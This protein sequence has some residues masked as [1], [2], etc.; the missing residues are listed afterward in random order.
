MIRRTKY[1]LLFFCVIHLSLSFSQNQSDSLETFLKHLTADDTLKVNTLNALCRELRN[2]GIYPQA[3]EYG[4]QAESISRKLD[5]KVGLGQALNNLGIIQDLQG[6]YPG[7]LDYYFKALKVCE[8]AGD[9]RGHAR[10]LNNIGII[11]NYQNNND[12]AREYYLKA[13]KIMEQSGDKRGMSMALN[14]VGIIYKKQQN[15]SKALYYYFKALK[16]REE[17]GDQQSVAAS[18][19]NIGN[20]YDAAGEYEK[21]KEYHLKSLKIR[22][23]IEDKNG[24]TMTYINLSRL[25]QVQKNYPEGIMYAEKSLK[26]AGEIGS[27]ALAEE[28]HQALYEIYLKMNNT[29]KALEHYKKYIAARDTIFNKENTEQTMRAEMNFEFERQKQQEKLLQEKRDALH[30]EEMKRQR[31]LIYSMSAGLLFLL[32]FALVIFSNYRQKKNANKMLEEKNSIIEEKNKNITDSINYARRIQ[33]AILPDTDEIYS[34]LQECFILY[35]PKDIVSGDFYYFAESGSKI[36]IAAA[37]CTGHGV[38]GAFMSM[39]GNDALN[40]IIIGKGITTP[41][42]ILSKLHDGVRFALKQDTSKTETSDGM[43]L[44]LCSIDRSTNLV[45]YAGAL[46]NL[47]IARKGSA[48]IEIIKANKQSIG[49]LKSD[50]KKTFS[51]QVIP[52]QKGDS[53][54]MLTDGYADQFGGKDGKKFM[55]RQLK[56]FLISIQSKNMKKQGEALNERIEEWKGNREQVD[57]ILVIGIRL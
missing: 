17:L 40:E 22:E 24:I 10:A 35:K 7:A 3:H 18:Y 39:I 1:I 5:Y 11:Y 38:P 13:L 55:M 56:D 57:D 8:D 32:A 43:D 52:L 4:I 6:D 27:L 37:D 16:L 44:A 33:N 9:K 25:S 53:I 49:G 21:A 12:K 48:E 15:Y 45:E 50:E 31:W 23:Q 28:A 20:M 36:I 2:T 34:K 14:N 46:R 29:G 42:E 41:G 54:Y 19:G 51:N 30:A 47:Y 26:L